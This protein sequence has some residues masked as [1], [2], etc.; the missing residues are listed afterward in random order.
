M[1][2]MKR[3]LALALSAAMTLGMT[4]CGDT[5]KTDSKSADSS[6]P[7]ASS[8]AEESA[9]ESTAE[10]E[11]A[12][13][14]E[15]KAESKAE[16]KPAAEEENL[17]YIGEKDGEKSTYSVKLTNG[18]EK[19]IVSFAI[20]YGDDEFGENLLP[21]GENFVADESRML[22][23]S[24]V[25]SGE[26]MTLGDFEVEITFDDDKSFVLHGF[27]LTDMISGEIRLMDD[28]AFLVYTNRIGDNKNTMES[29]AK[30]A[31]EARKAE[32]AKTATTTTTTTAQ[33]ETEPQTEA[34]TETQATEAPAVTEAPA[35]EAPAETDAAQS[36]EGGCMG[37]DAFTF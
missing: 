24:H 35:T 31:E 32:E 33:P 36:P 11:S 22:N 23:Y 9:P 3:F 28:Y 4:A 21:D 13:P 16:E 12:A 6:K 25:V 5:E 20:R 18:T 1:K 37:D 2:D 10:P 15:S 7:A 27:P 29:E 30:A 19:D 8:A 14:T 17:K 26:V 34:P